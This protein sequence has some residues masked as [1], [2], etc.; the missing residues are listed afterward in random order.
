MSQTN[1][2]LLIAAGS[3][4][5]QSGPEIPTTLLPTPWS[6]VKDQYYKQLRRQH[7]KYFHFSTT[8]CVKPRKSTYGGLCGGRNIFDRRQDL[9]KDAGRVGCRTRHRTG[10]RG[11]FP[12]FNIITK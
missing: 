5:F 11:N 10:A 2:A 1:K 12:R 4:N 6:A 9:G 7:Q 8:A 3:G